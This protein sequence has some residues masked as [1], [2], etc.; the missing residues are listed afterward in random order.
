MKKYQIIWASKDK[1][2]KEIIGNAASK[3]PKD[4]TII[5]SNCGYCNKY[6]LIPQTT[7]KLFNILGRIY[8]L[9]KVLRSCEKNS[10]VLLQY[11][12]FNEKLFQYIVQFIPK[13]KYVT[14]IHDM[15][16]IRE[17]GTI[18]KAEI[19]SLSIFDEIIVHSPE[20]KD[21]LMHYL[22]TN[23]TYHILECFPY[24]TNS[25]CQKPPLSNEI[26]FAGNIDKSP[27]LKDFIPQLKD[28]K[29]KL[30]GRMEQTLPKSDYVSYCGM[31]NPDHISTLKG[32]WGLVW[33]GTSISS[34]SGTWGKYLEIIAPH[35]FSLYI[36]SGI[37][38]IVWEKSAMARL[39]NQYGIGLTISSLYELEEKIKSV[40]TSQ[41]KSM[42]TSINIL[43][44][45]LRKGNNLINIIQ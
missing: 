37:P 19:K 32:S 28:I 5:A 24:L 30:Y 2:S 23:T 35:K 7:Y 21:Y 17:T 40:S 13:R 29:L 8:S 38:V 22:P 10:K 6:A 34:C 11:P 43:Q 15:N 41:Y 39:V 9:I 26:C 42:L 31:F 12:C 25:I 45:N 18:S 1:Q 14:I 20:M 36:A 4:V 33:D 16:S 27:F 3:A 44:N